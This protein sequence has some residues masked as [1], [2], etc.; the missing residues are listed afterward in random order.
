[1][2]PVSELS[3]LVEQRV[4]SVEILGLPCLN[5]G[6]NLNLTSDDMAYLHRQGISVDDDNDPPP[7]IFPYHNRNG[8]AVGYRKESID[9]GHK[10]IYTRPM[11]I[12]RITTVSR[13]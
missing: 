4:C 9:R 3:L 12:L 13:Q 5:S 10:K 1:M 11:M 7:K 2:L 8:V 6:R